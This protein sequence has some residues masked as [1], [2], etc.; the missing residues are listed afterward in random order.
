MV[1]TVVASY[2]LAPLVSFVEGS[3][4]RFSR[5]LFE[6]WLHSPLL[7]VH[8]C[9]DAATHFEDSSHVEV[10]VMRMKGWVER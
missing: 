6:A 1:V 3:W 2:I 4:M 10:H 5:G 7:S 8:T 9:S